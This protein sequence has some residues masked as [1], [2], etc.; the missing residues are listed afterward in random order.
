MISYICERGD[1]F[2]NKSKQEGC[3]YENDQ[4]GGKKGHNEQ[5]RIVEAVGRD[6]HVDPEKEKEC[7][8]QHRNNPPYPPKK[9]GR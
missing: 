3:T 6:E 7:P 9:R 1:Q 8:Q 5:E 2:E 4:A